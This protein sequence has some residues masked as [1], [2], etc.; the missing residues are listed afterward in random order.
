MGATVSIFCIFLSSFLLPI[1]II[2][3]V[4]FKNEKLLSSEIF[5]ERFGILFEGVNLKNKTSRIYLFVYWARRILLIGFFLLI[6]KD[7]GSIVLIIT[8]FSNI[9]YT[10]YIGCTKRLKNR[11][12]NYQEMFNEYIVSGCYYM[13]MI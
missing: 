3:V 6:N 7:L 9:L 10:L 12:L 4:S 1:T 8:L 2:L 11:N 5:E 13:K